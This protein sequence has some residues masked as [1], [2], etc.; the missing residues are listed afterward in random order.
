MGDFRN[1]LSIRRSVD[2]G[3]IASNARRS[4][5]S[6]LAREGSRTFTHS[7]RGWALPVGDD[8]G[9]G[10]EGDRKG[11]SGHKKGATKAPKRQPVPKTIGGRTTR[12]WPRRRSAGWATGSFRRARP[13]AAAWMLPQELQPSI[14]P[15]SRPVGTVRPM[16]VEHQPSR[17]TSCADADQASRS[18]TARKGSPFPCGNTTME[19]RNTSKGATTLP[20][21]CDRVIRP[22]GSPRVKRRRTPRPR[23]GPPPPLPAPHRPCR[24]RPHRR[25]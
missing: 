1:N 10:V 19:S 15:A 16:L 22:E 8:L 17:P 4:S 25:R 21:R 14:R 13:R 20:F 3:E 5:R 23:S 6:P 7:T 18:G 9:G 12:V 24:N 2:R 11:K